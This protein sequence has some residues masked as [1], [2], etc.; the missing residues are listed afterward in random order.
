MLKRLAVIALLGVSLASAK[1]YTITLSNACQAG[2]AQLKPGQYTLKLDGAKVVLVDSRGKSIETTARVET[3]ER[4]FDQTSI[5]I[6]RAD[7]IARLQSITLA[8]SKSKVI[9][10]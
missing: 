8:G 4:K 5:V 9:F 6:S 7:G 2:G 10:E 3:A 1:S